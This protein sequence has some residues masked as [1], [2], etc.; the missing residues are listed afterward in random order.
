MREAEQRTAERV[1]S[2]ETASVLQIRDNPSRKRWMSGQ[3]RNHQKR[4]FLELTGP[5]FAQG[6][7]YEVRAERSGTFNTPC[8]AHL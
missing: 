5:D 8:W 3:S 7:R 2:Y 4:I 1:K 6:Q